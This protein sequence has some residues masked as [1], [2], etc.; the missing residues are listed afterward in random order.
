MPSGPDEPTTIIPARQTRPFHRAL[1]T[2]EP[3]NPTG[4]AL[5]DYRTD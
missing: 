3:T 4:G 2:A 5:V 1:G